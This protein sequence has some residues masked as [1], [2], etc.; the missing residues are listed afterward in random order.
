MEAGD[1][2][3]DQRVPKEINRKIINHLSDSICR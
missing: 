1:H 3:F 2:C